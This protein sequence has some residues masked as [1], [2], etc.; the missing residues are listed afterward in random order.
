M[1]SLVEALFLVFVV[2]ETWL[3]LSLVLFSLFSKLLEKIWEKRKM[4]ENHANSRLLETL[5]TVL[6]V[7]PF[8]LSIIIEAIL[9]TVLSK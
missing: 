8:V 3:A 2:V 7:L 5:D 6:L 4:S 1:V 9:I